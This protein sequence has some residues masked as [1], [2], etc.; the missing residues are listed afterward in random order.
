MIEEV[1][2]KDRKRDQQKEYQQ[3]NEQIG[4]SRM[5][6]I[7]DSGENL[8]V[9]SRLEALSKAREEGL[10]L[11][12]LAENSGDGMP[13]VKIMD[14]GKMLYAKKKK[15]VDAKKKQKII[16]VKEVKL[17]PKIDEHDYQTKLNQAIQ[18]LNDGNRV[19]FTLMFRG[20]EMATRDERGHQMFDKIDKTL[21]EE[22]IEN[23][24]REK[25]MALGSF[26]SRVYYI[27]HHK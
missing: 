20:R 2:L 4:Y 21:S 22:G 11:V 24:E 14:F 1:R 7:T 15:L 27:K 12:L 16:K 17:R 13:I 19:K 25:D 18:F 26:W 6:V 23:L 9:L 8:G 10:D 5:Q 3:I